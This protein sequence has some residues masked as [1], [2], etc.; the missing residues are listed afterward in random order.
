MTTFANID[1][2][3]IASAKQIWAVANK[4][5]SLCT[6]DKSERYGLTKVYNAI[7]N[8]L[9]GEA[10][11]THGDIQGFFEAET[12]PKNIQAKIKSKKAPKPKAA[13]K[14]KKAAKPEPEVQEYL[15]KTEK[16]VK[17]VKKVAENSN[18]KKINARIDSIE[19][20]FDTLE[21]KVGDIES[22]LQMILE[23]V[24]AK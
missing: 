4:F 1:E 21:S 17:A 23:A 7:L 3:R 9:H 5:S 19:G 8:S 16:P 14:S 18:V 15:D 12:V 6:A 13:K 10:K 11:L 22:G 2:N 24:Q 20:R